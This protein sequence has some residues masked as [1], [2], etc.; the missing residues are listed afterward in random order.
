MRPSGV[1]KVVR[2]FVWYY[3]DQICL[4]KS[5][6]AWTVKFDRKMLITKLNGRGLKLNRADPARE[7]TNGLTLL[8]S[9]QQPS[10]HGCV[11]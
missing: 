7:L 9:L 10:L 2:N 3:K 4:V 11:L 1:V 8:P 6:M 5:T